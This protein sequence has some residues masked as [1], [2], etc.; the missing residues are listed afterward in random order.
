MPCNPISS[1]GQHEPIDSSSSSCAICVKVSLV[2]LTILFLGGGIA[3]MSQNV[4]LAPHLRY[5]TGGVLMGTSLIITLALLYYCKVSQKIT[6]SDLPPEINIEK[7]PPPTNWPSIPYTQVEL[8]PPTSGE[9]ATLMALDMQVVNSK[10]YVRIRPDTEHAKAWIKVWDLE[11]R[12]WESLDLEGLNGL[13]VLG[14]KIEDDLLYV[15]H[16]YRLSIWN[17]K[18][19]SK[20]REIRVNGN[21]GLALHAKW[22]IVSDDDD[23]YFYTKDTLNLVY[24]L[25]G[26]ENY[27]CDEH[28]F[29]ACVCSESGLREFVA[30]PFT[31]I[32][33]HPE[34]SVLFV[35]GSI[36]SKYPH[37]QKLDG[38]LYGFVE[39]WYLYN[40]TFM[41]RTLIANDFQNNLYMFLPSGEKRNLNSKARPF[42]AFNQTLIVQDWNRTS[43]N[44][45]KEIQFWS[46]PEG[47][48]L[49][50][51][52][53]P[54]Y[55][56][57][58]SLTVFKDNHLIVGYDDG[59]IYLLTL[60]SI[61]S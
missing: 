33:T 40:S 21:H 29:V 9:K 39:D 41:D 51:I 44:P 34:N 26:V 24:T 25:K 10:V 55:H 50:G 35:Q 19:G 16:S 2:V 37:D 14:F 27:Y 48:V 36:Q 5:I 28:T 49:G 47:K 45:V 4:V 22:C 13:N 17:L 56:E 20:V 54:T 61:P 46:M 15:S 42:Y 58:T 3:I 59:S 30:I 31:T 38:T 1:S 8:C 7:S 57:I 6:S 11:T 60:D 43:E 23:A 32:E 53:I 52:P 18:N 12:S